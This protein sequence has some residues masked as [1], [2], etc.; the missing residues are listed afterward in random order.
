VRAFSRA[1]DI[2]LPAEELAEI[3]ALAQESA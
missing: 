3:E 2:H 1:T